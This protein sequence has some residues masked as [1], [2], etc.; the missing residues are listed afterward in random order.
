ML[1]LQVSIAQGVSIGSPATKISAHGQ[2]RQFL[3]CE[4]SPPPVKEAAHIGKWMKS[5]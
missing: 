3:G 1:F 4:T 2:N 5:V